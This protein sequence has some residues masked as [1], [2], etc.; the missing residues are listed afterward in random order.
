MALAQR[1]QR[2]TSILRANLFQKVRCRCTAG[3][4][5]GAVPQEAQGRPYHILHPA[6][7]FPP[8]FFPLLITSEILGMQRSLRMQR[9]RS[10]KAGDQQPR[11]SRQWRSLQIPKHVQVSSII[12]QLS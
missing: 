4:L 11:I 3:V 10:C 6:P 8:S 2:G 5:Q 1:A 7:Y 9:P 12:G